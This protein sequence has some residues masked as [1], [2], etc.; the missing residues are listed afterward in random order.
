MQPNKKMDTLLNEMAVYKTELAKGSV[1]SQLHRTKNIIENIPDINISDQQGYT[2]LMVA[3]MQYKTDIVKLLL[4]AGAD[5]NRG[6]KDGV[7]P[8]AVVFL[9]NTDNRE[10]IIRLLIE[11]GA[12]PSLADKPGQTA[13]DFAEI[14]NADAH[15]I[16]MLEQAN[17]RL[18][19]V[20]RGV[21]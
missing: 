21:K 7:R 2:Y 11:Y 10:E 20:L 5:P 14:T 16:K 6:C 13:F 17:F 18:H 12:D 3:V 9:K 4:E 8:L 19:G 15:L 1:T